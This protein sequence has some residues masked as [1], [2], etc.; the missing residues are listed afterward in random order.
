MW[1]KGRLALGPRNLRGAGVAG[2]VDSLLRLFGLASL[3]WSVAALPSFWQLLPARDASAQI[4]TD[5]R[6]RPNVLTDLRTRIQAIPRP[7]LQ[8]PEF[9]QADALISLR[10]ADEMVQKMRPEEA[11]REV[12]AAEQ[13]VKTALSVTPT[14][15][16]LWLMLY[17]VETARSGFDSRNIGYFD[18]SY[19]TGPRE[20]WIA[21]RRNRLGLAVFPALSKSTQDM[22][23]VEFSEMVDADFIDDAVLNL[24]GIGWMQR[25]RLLASL[26]HVDISSRQALVK[27]LLRDAVKVD[28]PGI[29]SDDRPW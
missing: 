15:S 12:A 29:V 19:A 5:A 16:F 26:A 27:R 14:D 3:V 10:I 6:F 17:S 18:R 24:E 7:A 21:L 2:S 25:D 1:T 20:G 23:I 4:I 8:P 28:V 11:D 9:T 22:V 13:K